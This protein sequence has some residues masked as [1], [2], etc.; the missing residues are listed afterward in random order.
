MVAECC[1]FVET[2]DRD[3]ERW[4]AHRAWA[5]SLR[6]D[7]TVITFN[8]DLAFELL[9]PTNNLQLPGCPPCPDPNRPDLYKLHGSIDWKRAKRGGRFERQP[10]APAFS[11]MTPNGRERGVATPGPSKLDRS[12]ELKDLWERA[13]N[14]VK[15]AEAVFFIGYRFPPTDVHAR[16]EVLAA[17][18]RNPARPTVGVVLGPDARNDTTQRL[19]RLLG[20]VLSTDVEVYPYYCEEFFTLWTVQAKAQLV[21]FKERQVL[22]VR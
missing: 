6:G 14:A 20:S 22:S 11:V 21:R 19:V 9:C 2:S 8:Y 12:E 18:A 13:M 16:N 10:D 5:E 15:A 1:A 7:S 4:A 17:L 3:S